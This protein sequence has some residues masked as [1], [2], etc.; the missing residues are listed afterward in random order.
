MRI[1]SDAIVEGHLDLR[2]FRLFNAGDGIDGTDLVTKRQLDRLLDLRAAAVEPVRESRAKLRLGTSGM[3]RV[4]PFASRGAAT[5]AG[6]LF[7]ADDRN[8]V[9]WICTGTVWQYA[10]GIEYGTLSPDQ[11]PTLTTEDAGYL[12]GST[13]F[14]RLYKWTGAAWNDAPGQPTRGSIQWFDAS[15]HADFV[16]GAG[17]ALCDGTAS[18]SRSTP[19]GN[20]TT[21]TIV[22]MTTTTAYARAVSGATG[23]TGGSFSHTHTITSG[24]T[25]VE[26]ADTVV[27]SGSGVT[28]AALNHTHG[29]NAA[30]TTSGPSVGA[31]PYV[32]LRPYMRL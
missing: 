27:Q 6:E 18:V 5:K 15:A 4:G 25:G 10:F 28:V 29:N 23:G 3:V 32:D 12:F 20:V 13:D 8:Y 31:P 19:F 9:G 24:T 7:L 17:W 22:D 26:S 21:F 14:Q 30:Q 1:P 2:G 11:K 16:P